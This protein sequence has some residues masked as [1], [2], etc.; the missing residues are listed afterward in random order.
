[1]IKTLLVTPSADS[2]FARAILQSAPLDFGDHTPAT[3][4]AVGSFALTQ[5]GCSNVACL[6]GL[7]VPAV[8]NAQTVTYTNSSQISPAVA[9]S[10]PFRPWVDGV[11]VRQ[12]FIKAINGANGGLTNKYRQIIF[13]TV[14]DEAAS[15]CHYAVCEAFVRLIHHLRSQSDDLSERRPE[16]GAAQLL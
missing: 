14:L 5:L 13:T 6:Q 3:S 8:L 15:V 11:L 7:S 16:S 9:Q 12:D 1:M 4:D 10:E 2:L